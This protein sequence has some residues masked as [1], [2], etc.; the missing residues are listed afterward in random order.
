MI[1]SLLQYYID[2]HSNTFEN[3]TEYACCLTLVSTPRSLLF[4][5]APLILRV[6]FT[7]DMTISTPIQPYSTPSG[8]ASALKTPSAAPPFLSRVNKARARNPQR[9]T[10]YRPPRNG[11]LKFAEGLGTRSVVLWWYDTDEGFEM[12]YSGVWA[13]G[14]VQQRSLGAPAG[15]QSRRV[16]HPSAHGD[17]GHR[18]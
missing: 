17:Y 4:P 12:A 11:I 7:T 16:V 8:H 14:A 10:H 5:S 3:C 2:F 18:S 15:L 13:G 6:H 9:R 1:Q